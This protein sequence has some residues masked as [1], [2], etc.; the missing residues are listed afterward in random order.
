[1]DEDRERWNRKYE[2]RETPG[3]PIDALGSHVHLARPGRALDL[4]CGLGRHAL[5]LAEQGFEVDAVDIS[6]VALSRINHPRIRTGLTDLDHYHIN[7][8]CYDLIVNAWFLNR[9]LW[10]D[11][12]AGLKS[13]GVLIFQTALMENCHVGNPAFKLRPGELLTGFEGLEV[14]YH[15]EAEGIATLVAVRVSI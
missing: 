5:F 13:G 10:P 15:Q 7:P 12:L 1:M 9:R 4:A 6:D 8:A 11:I 2:D 3:S 14:Y